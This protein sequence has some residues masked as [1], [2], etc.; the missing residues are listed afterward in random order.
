MLNHEV[1]NFAGSNSELC[2]ALGLTPPAGAPT[3]WANYTVRAIKARAAS[4]DPGAEYA[5]PR[6]RNAAVS[7]PRRTATA[8]LPSHLLAL[9]PACSL[10]LGGGDVKTAIKEAGKVPDSVVEVLAFFGLNRSENIELLLRWSGI[11]TATDKAR[12]RAIDL[13]HA[14]ITA[15]KES[16]SIDFFEAIEKALLTVAILGESHE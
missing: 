13:L 6:T 5:A 3:H 1:V 10:K 16:E 2:A 9:L 12:S 7:S 4:G 11:P 8:M 14:A 15:C